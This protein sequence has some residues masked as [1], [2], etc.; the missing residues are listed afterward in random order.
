MRRSKPLTCTCFYLEGFN[1]FANHEDNHQQRCN[2]IGPPP[3]EHA[4]ESQ[5][6]EQGGGKVGARQGFHTIGGERTAVQSAS[7]PWFCRA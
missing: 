4:V 6:Y 3:A 2:W 5:T 1:S 7:H